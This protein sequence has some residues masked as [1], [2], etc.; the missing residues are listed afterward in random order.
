MQICRALWAVHSLGRCSPGCETGKYH[1]A[2]IRCHSDRLRCRQD[3]QCGK[4]RA[5]TQ[6]LGD[7]GICPLR[8]STESPSL[9]SARISTRWVSSS[10][11]CLQ[12]AIRRKNWRKDTWAG[13]WA[14][15]LMSI[16]ISGTVMSFI[17]CGRCKIVQGTIKIARI[18]RT[19]KKFSE[20][21]AFSLNHTNPTRVCPHCGAPLHEDSSFCPHC[22]ESV[23]PRTQLCPPSVL[24]RRIRYFSH[25]PG[26]IRSGSV[27][28]FFPPAAR[29]L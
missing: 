28:N 22:A 20:T 9:T 16:P 6:I 1:P 8:N 18:T 23:N 19:D 25:H 12:A 4:R 13:S 26:R 11:S 3:T 2:R 27:G 14:A 5:D 7:G 29:Y 15:A 17:S 21:E 10:T 24:P